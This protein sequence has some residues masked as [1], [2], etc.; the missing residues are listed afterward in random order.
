MI[1][2]RYQLEISTGSEPNVARIGFLG[3]NAQTRAVHYFMRVLEESLDYVRKN[4]LNDVE[5][6]MEKFARI[7]VVRGGLQNSNPNK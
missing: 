1:C 4:N 5:A 7:D 3:Y 6:A 2:F